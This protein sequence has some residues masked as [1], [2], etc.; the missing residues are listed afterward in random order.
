MT[1]FTIGGD[2]AVHRLGFGAMRITGAGVWGWPADRDAAKGVLKRAVELGVELI[3]TADAYGPETSEY[4]I[5]EALHPYDGLTIATKG[6]LERKGP[7]KWQSNGRPEHLTIAC[8]NSLRRLEVDCIDLYQL[9][10]V[11]DDVPL[12]ESLGALADLQKEGKI[13]HIGVSNMDLP[14]LK[15]AR[16]VVDVVSVQNRYNLADRKHEDVVDYCTEHGIGFIPW[17]PLA[18]G[19]L[20]EHESFRQLAEQHDASAG[21]LALAW[22]LKRSPVMLPIPGTSSTAHLEQN[23]AARDVT[24]S[25][26]D[27]EALSELAGG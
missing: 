23:V 27:F 8:L 9:H 20:V 2:T 7:G 1:T 25:D 21:Q 14:Q 26:E 4:L 22:L 19:D 18:A 17:F 10:T 13:R 12:E 16:E 15:R 24:L 3:D 11:D 6:G 5:A